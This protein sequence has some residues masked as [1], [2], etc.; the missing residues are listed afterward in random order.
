MRA[1]QVDQDSEYRAEFELACHEHGITLHENRAHEPRQ[2]AFVERETMIHRILGAIGVL[3]AAS[4]AWR[5]V[6]A[7]R[8]AF[9][10]TGHALFASIE[11]DDL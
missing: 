8:E 3:L 9:S 11:L 7:V 5:I 4:S 2:N 1:I 6:G 10:P